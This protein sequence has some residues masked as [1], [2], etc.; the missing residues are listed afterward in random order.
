MAIQVAP[1]GNPFLI[2]GADQQIL[3]TLGG[4]DSPSAGFQAGQQLAQRHFNPLSLG[5]IGTDAPSLDRD[6]NLL[7]IGGTLRRV[8]DSVDRGAGT[9][10]LAR[11]GL[12]DLGVLAGQT[13]SRNKGNERI[14]DRRDQLTRGNRL[15]DIADNLSR[16][17][18]VRDLVSRRTSALQGLSQPEL[19]ARRDQGDTALNQGLESALRSIRSR[20]PGASGPA[21]S[22]AALP[23]VNA[24]AQGKTNLE[25]DLIVEDANRRRAALD[26]FENTVRGVEGDEFARLFG[27]T[28]AGEDLLR[29]DVAADEALVRGIGQDTF[30]QR[31]QS[32]QALDDARLRQEQFE[33][34]DELA[35]LDRLIGV[36]NTARQDIFNR[37]K[38]DLDQLAKEKAG[39]LGLIFGGGQ[40]GTASQAQQEANEIARE[41]IAQGSA[42]SIPEV[43]LPDFTGL[44]SSFSDFLSPSSSSNFNFISP[45]SF[46]QGGLDKLTGF[47]G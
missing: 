46:T 45:N 10:S 36:Q 11:R 43:E 21:A 26:S 28:Q 33:R 15:S 12:N 7:D 1:E 8:Q 30:N 2:P 41:A 9:S 38:F 47:R 22:R 25:R 42:F 20:F 23:A 32:S 13:R 29:R 18:N 19:Q 34:T 6:P 16:S 40:L 39:R 35:N 3:N 24:F 14:L 5:R 4:A 17:G 44:F 31:L 27:S 37:N